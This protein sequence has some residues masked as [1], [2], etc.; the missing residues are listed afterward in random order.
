METKYGLV[1]DALNLKLGK[2]N[3]RE[4]SSVDFQCDCEKILEWAHNNFIIDTIEQKLLI[5]QARGIILGIE[6]EFTEPIL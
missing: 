5:E 6:K 1:I 4:L 2:L 3:D